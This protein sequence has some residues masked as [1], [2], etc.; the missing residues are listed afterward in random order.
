MSP[1][2]WLPAKRSTADSSCSSTSPRC[3]PVHPARTPL[4][5]RALLSEPLDVGV[6]I[7]L[8]GNTLHEDDARRGLRQE[9]ARQAGCSWVM[10]PCP[11]TP[12]PPV[13]GVV[14]LQR[15]ALLPPRTS[16]PGGWARPPPR[17]EGK[18]WGGN[19][20]PF[21]L[22][23]L[24]PFSPRGGGGHTIRTRASP[25]RSSGST[26]SRGAIWAQKRRRNEQPSSNVAR[27]N[28]TA[29]RIRSEA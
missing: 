22:H 12:P 5:E 16:A 14:L 18:G 3:S 13:P 8:A 11:N 20:E 1:S 23:D 21:G 28:F 4:P 15:V 2:R 24:S 6:E 26:A 10:R 7:T 19:V 17:S 27:D 29:R 9:W 25:A